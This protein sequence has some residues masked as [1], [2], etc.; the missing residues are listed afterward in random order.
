MRL[1][2][3]KCLGIHGLQLSEAVNSQDDVIALLGDFLPQ[4]VATDR[5]LLFTPAEYLGFGMH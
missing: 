5:N 3:A 1:Q 4:C 2:S